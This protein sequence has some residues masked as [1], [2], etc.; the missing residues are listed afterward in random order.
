MKGLKI[1]GKEGP[2]EK[3]EEFKPSENLF[4]ILSV[5]GASWW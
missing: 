1:N 2:N 3:L 5:L 4:S